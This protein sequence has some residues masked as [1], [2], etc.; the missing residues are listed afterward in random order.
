MLGERLRLA[1][2]RAGL[3]L[4]DLAANIDHRASAQAI[5]KYENGVMLP[6]ASVLVALGKALS[7]SL[8]FLMSNQ[9]IAL[10]GVEFR[11]KSGTT[12]GDRAKVEAEVIDQV[13]RY[14]AIEAVLNVESADHAFSARQRVEVQRIEDAETQ[15]GV[16]RTEWKLGLDPIASLTALLEERGIK[17]IQAILPESVAGL[18]CDVR[19]PEPLPSVPVVVVNVQS[20][21][22]RLRFTLAHELAHRIIGGNPNIDDEKA[23]HRFASA[24]LMPREHLWAETGGVRHALAYSEIVRLKHL[25]GVSATA[26]LMRLKDIGVLTEENISYAFRTYAQ[27]WR[28]AEPQPLDKGGPFYILERPERFENLVYRALAE[29]V[30]SLPKAAL[31][32]KKPVSEVEFAI[33]GPP[34]DNAHSH[35]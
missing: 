7:V 33:K 34:F 31:L 30:I 35:Q 26:L 11:K 27:Q 24:F 2:K 19:R 10:A 1:R 21:I 23:A 14:L 5:S 9:V 25:Y 18:T 28:R 20:N 13:E 29:E 16:L 32:L 22:E 3:S 15:A 17:V 6:S 4:R 8:D 12:A